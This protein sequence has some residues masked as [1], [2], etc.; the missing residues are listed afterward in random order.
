[1]EDF[2]YQCPRTRLAVYLPAAIPP[3]E[4][5]VMALFVAINGWAVEAR[6]AAS[7]GGVAVVGGGAVL[8]GRS[9]WRG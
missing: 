7:G 6:M 5:E 8:A 4:D 3:S 9:R 1:M 2:A